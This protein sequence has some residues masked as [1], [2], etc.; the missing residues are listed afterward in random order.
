[1]IAPDEQGASSPRLRPNDFGVGEA[2][3]GLGAGFVLASLLV[4]LFGELGGHPRHPSGFGIDVAS[5]LGLWTGLVGC[6]VAASRRARRA[7]AAPGPA[8]RTA[9]RRAPT[10]APGLLRALAEDYGLAI[11]PWP[12]VPLGL[13]VGLASQYLL[14]PVLELPLEPFVP[15]LFE[16]L[17]QPAVSL[18]SGATGAGLVALGVLV[19]LGSPLVEELFFRGLLLRGLAGKLAP[20]GKRLGPVASV[21]L[22]G[23]VFGL[24]HFELL[25]LV[26]L[27][28]FGCVLGALAWRTGRLGPG[29]VAH[30]AFNT[31][32]FVTVA[33]SH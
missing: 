9:R 33:R 1:M 28:G 8:E 32:T 11:R 6:V 16:R 14:V 27:V 26:A 13:L 15:H 30:M 12:D 29:I 4:S 21:A 23:I 20:L 10:G 22:V 2:L 18:T 3:V 5:L 7:R 17:G 25:Q 31:A 24:V 19:C